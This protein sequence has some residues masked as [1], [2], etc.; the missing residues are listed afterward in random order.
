VPPAEVGDLRD[1]GVDWQRRH[2]LRFYT[3]S[4]DIQLWIAGSNSE[5]FRD[6]SGTSSRCGGAVGSARMAASSR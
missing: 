2:H 6:R 4:S 5:R 3:V 1:R